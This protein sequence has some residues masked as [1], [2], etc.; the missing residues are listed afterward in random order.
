[1]FLVGLDGEWI[2]GQTIRVHGGIILE[3]KKRPRTT[4]VKTTKRKIPRQLKLEPFSKFRGFLSF[5][6][7]GLMPARQAKNLCI[8]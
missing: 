1:M 7:S 8:V 3:N 6:S 2:N 5:G 4:L